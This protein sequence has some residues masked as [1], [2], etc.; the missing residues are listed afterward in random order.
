M[1]LIH[2]QQHSKS[3]HTKGLVCAHVYIMEKLDKLWEYL[4][5]KIVKEFLPESVSLC[6]V[7]VIVWS[8]LYLTCTCG[9]HK[10]KGIALML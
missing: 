10:M 3:T 9:G 8:F 2:K 6:S 1:K 5:N 7:M 4:Y